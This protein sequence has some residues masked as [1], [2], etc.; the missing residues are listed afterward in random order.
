MNEEY[1][2]SL[3]FLLLQYWIISTLTFTVIISALPATQSLTIYELLPVFDLLIFVFI[4]YASSECIKWTRFSYVPYSCEVNTSG[5]LSSHQAVPMALKPRL[6]ISSWLTIY[7]CMNLSR[8]LNM[9]TLTLNCTR[10]ALWSVDL[11]RYI[12]SFICSK[13][14]GLSHFHSRLLLI[15][16]IFCWL[17]NFGE[18]YIKCYPAL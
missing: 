14:S 18:N 13:L 8:E 1:M 12:C 3:L 6:L 15:C 11:N 16:R 9:A 5:M 2:V 17:G 4:Q 7:Q 10:K